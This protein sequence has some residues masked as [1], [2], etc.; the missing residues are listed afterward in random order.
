[1]ESGAVEN[2]ALR[3]ILYIHCCFG[4]WPMS[5]NPKNLPVAKIATGNSVNRV[6]RKL[7]GNT[8]Q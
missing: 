8:G 4:L 1:M 7:E 6:A 3:L 2:T 5:T